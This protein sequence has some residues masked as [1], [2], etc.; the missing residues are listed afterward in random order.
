MVPC[1]DY[2]LVE[3]REVDIGR[4]VFERIVIRAT[5]FEPSEGL[6]S[7]KKLGRFA[8]IVACT[9]QQG[10]LVSLFKPDIELGLISFSE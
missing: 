9:L 8:H 5:K 2:Q 4:S 10:L 1:Q 6:T 3:V 7:W